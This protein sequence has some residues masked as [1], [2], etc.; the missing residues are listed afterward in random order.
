V[1]ARSCSRRSSLGLG[2][3]Q[4]RAVGE[5]EADARVDAEAVAARLEDERVRVGAEPAA[6]RLRGRASGGA[7]ALGRRRRG[8][9]EWSG[10]ALWGARKRPG[11]GGNQVTR[12][13]AESFSHGSA[14][15][16]TAGVPGDGRRPSETVRV[17]AARWIVRPSTARA[18]TGRSNSTF[19][20]P[21]AQ[22]ALAEVRGR[23][24]QLDAHVCVRPRSQPM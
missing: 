8:E 18:R 21:R 22:V 20:G 4:V 7:R 13:G 16:R 23:R 11:P 17:G 5:G 2:V 15:T 19:T 10:R 24:G 14:A 12:V 9:G 6:G 3:R 1:R